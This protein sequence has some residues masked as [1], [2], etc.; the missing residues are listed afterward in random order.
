MMENFPPFTAKHLDAF[1]DLIDATHEDVVIC[2]AIFKPSIALQR[3]DPEYFRI[4]LVDFANEIPEVE[5]D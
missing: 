5:E 1:M 2:G 4:L 3:C